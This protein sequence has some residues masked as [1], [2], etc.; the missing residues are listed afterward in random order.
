MIYLLTYGN[1]GL[2]DPKIEQAYRR[3]HMGRHMGRHLGR[4]CECRRAAEGDDVTF[5]SERHIQTGDAW[6]RQL[7]TDVEILA[8]AAELS[9]HGRRKAA[10][11]VAANCKYYCSTRKSTRRSAVAYGL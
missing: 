10:S 7:A 2:F 5:E 11:T 8:R 3:R 9:P 4:G 6:L 1:F